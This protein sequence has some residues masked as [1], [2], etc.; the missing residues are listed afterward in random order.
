MLGVAPIRSTPGG[1]P[2]REVGP[3]RLGDL[4]ALSVER[5]PEDVRERLSNPE[6]PA[7]LSTEELQDNRVPEARSEWLLA[8]EEAWE[9][10]ALKD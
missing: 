8:I 6:E 7:T 2:D 1:S 5:L 4:T 3:G 9:E 10:K